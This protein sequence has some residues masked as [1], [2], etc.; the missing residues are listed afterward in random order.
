M[1]TL[2]GLPYTMSSNVFAVSTVTGPLLSAGGSS[3]LTVFSSFPAC[4]KRR[5]CLGTE[6]RERWREHTSQRHGPLLSAAGSAPGF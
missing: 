4:H 3:L 6:C 5:E 2:R 1:K